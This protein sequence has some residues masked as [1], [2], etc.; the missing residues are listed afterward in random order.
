MEHFSLFEGLKRKCYSLECSM[1]NRIHAEF[2]M[3]DASLK[4]DKSKV[5]QH[6]INGHLKVSHT[7]TVL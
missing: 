7:F 2:A 1:H 6:K 5:G 3:E 4:A